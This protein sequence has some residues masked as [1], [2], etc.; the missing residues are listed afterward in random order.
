[1]DMKKVLVFDKHTSEF[2]YELFESD[3][4][5]FL[6]D[7]CKVKHVEYNPETHI[8]DGGDYIR[9]K[10]VSMDEFNHIINEQAI[11][12]VCEQVILSE[13][14]INDQINN[15]A[16]AILEISKSLNISG[17]SISILE[18]Q[19]AFITECRETNESYK[20]AYRNHPD[21]DFRERDE[22]MDFLRD[23]MDDMVA[24][25]LGVHT[26]DL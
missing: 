7:N 18:D 23:N 19:M 6:L 14:L 2:L 20:N 5:K 3:I 22:K 26:I 25:K 11:S 15:I 9:G 12:G 17:D 13:Y 24:E 4:N 8:W 1:M 16:N 10:V 21:Y